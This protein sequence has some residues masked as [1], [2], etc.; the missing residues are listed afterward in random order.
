MKTIKSIN[1]K[2]LKTIQNKI[3]GLMMQSNCEKQYV[4]D[5]GDKI[6]WEKQS[7]LNYVDDRYFPKTALIQFA[8]TP[9]NIYFIQESE[10]GGADISYES[11]EYFYE[12]EELMFNI[13]EE[14]VLLVV[15]QDRL[16]AFYELQDLEPF[17]Y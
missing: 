15:L 5:I 4:N 16:D 10:N 7:H 14:D 12:I 11:D 9:K 1:Q 17:D 2:D 8:D 13:P 6:V 3:L